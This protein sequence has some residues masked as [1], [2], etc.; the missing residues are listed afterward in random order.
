MEKNTSFEDKVFTALEKRR[1]EAESLLEQ[2]FA[3]RDREIALQKAPTG[4][5]EE[6][7]FKAMKL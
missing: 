2:D 3:P 6:G 4:T 5:I 1:L 7:A